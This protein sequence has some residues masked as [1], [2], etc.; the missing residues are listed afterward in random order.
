MLGSGFF[1]RGWGGGVVGFLC[2]VLFLI[3]PAKPWKIGKPLHLWM[4]KPRQ[5][6]HV[7]CLRF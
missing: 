4:D 6:N 2:F 3:N 5:R 1:G 7:S